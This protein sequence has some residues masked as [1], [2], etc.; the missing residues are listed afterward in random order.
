MTLARSSAYYRPRGRYGAREAE[1]ATAIASV[2]ER[3]PAYGYRRVTHQLRRQGW[4]INHKRVARIM[5]QLG[6]KADLPPRRFAVT[7]DGAARS[8]FRNLAVNGRARWTPVD[9]ASL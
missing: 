4:A 7:S 6:L 9:A 5:R 3:W 2:C 8:P 1:L